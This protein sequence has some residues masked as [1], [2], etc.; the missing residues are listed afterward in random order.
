MAEEQQTIL[1][2]LAIAFLVGLLGFL[3]GLFAWW[4]MFPV[5]DFGWRFH[6]Y[7]TCAIAI[8]SFLLGLWRPEKTMD[9]LGVVGKK[10]WSFSSEVLSWFR[11]LR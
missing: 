9:V 7:A 2:R 11:F 4:V 6:W 3:V 1:E 5:L 10:L 8:V